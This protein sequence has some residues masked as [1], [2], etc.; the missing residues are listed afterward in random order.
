MPI[1][2]R[3]PSKI[4]IPESPPGCRIGRSGRIR[5]AC[6]QAARDDHIRNM[7]SNRLDDG[8]GLPIPVFPMSHGWSIIAVQLAHSFWCCRS[9]DGG[10]ESAPVVC[11]FSG[12]LDRHHGAIQA[13]PRVCCDTACSTMNSFLLLCR[14]SDSGCSTGC[15]MHTRRYVDSCA[16]C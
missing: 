11:P 8:I 15:G 10:R 14:D 12:H 5:N 9:G 7:R 13:T 6:L 3:N 2:S 4:L 16:L 1:A